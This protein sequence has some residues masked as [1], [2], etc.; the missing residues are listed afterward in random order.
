MRNCLVLGGT[1][2]TKKVL[3][4]LLDNYDKIYVTVAT[5]YGYEIFRE[6]ENEKI[7]IILKRF[8]EESLKDFISSFSIEEIIDTTHPYAKKISSLAKNISADININYTAM[9]RDTYLDYK[10]EKLVYVGCY[11][12]AV[13]FV[14]DRDLL[15]SFITTGSK[16]SHRF[17][18]IASNSYIR[19]LPSEESIAKVRRSGFPSK[20][21]IAMQGPF[22][23]DLNVAIIRQFG[24]K[25]IITKNS[26]ESGGLLEKI[27]SAEICKIPIIVVENE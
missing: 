12:D 20:N 25:S 17:S 3:N 4:K 11:E 18:P 1:S 22:N 23:V 26:G 21:I 14:L 7:K 13:N 16:N 10:Y 27:K 6:L 8:D 2:D 19:I 15:P 5:E 24:I 9:M